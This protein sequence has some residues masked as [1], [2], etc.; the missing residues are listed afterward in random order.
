MARA[1]YR[2]GIAPVRTA[3]ELADLLPI[4][5]FLLL[6]GHAKPVFPGTDRSNPSVKV[7]ILGIEPIPDTIPTLKGS[8]PVWVH[9]TQWQS[10]VVP[11]VDDLRT[12]WWAGV[13]PS[14][15]DTLT[16]PTNVLIPQSGGQVQ[17]P[18]GTV[19]G[20]SSHS[21]AAVGGLYQYE[22]GPYLQQLSGVIKAQAVAQGY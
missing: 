5:I 12:N 18:A 20:T 17:Y 1:D 11:V 16:L 4:P 14:T 21:T 7:G 3:T 15:G 2:T 13:D 10:V 19:V 22:V 8:L 6:K 9:W